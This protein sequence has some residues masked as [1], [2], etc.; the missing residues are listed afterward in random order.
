[1]QT[2]LLR[3]IRDEHL[4]LAAM[5]DALK[6]VVTR[7]PG[8]APQRFFEIVDS[9]LVYVKE[10]SEHVHYPKEIELIFPTVLQVAPDTLGAVARLEQSHAASV[11]ELVQLQALLAKWR[12]GGAPQRAAFERALTLCCQ[13]YLDQIRMEEASIL[14]AAEQLVND[15]QW[16]ALVVQH[17]QAA[18]AGLVPEPDEIAFEQRYNRIALWLTR[19]LTPTRLAHK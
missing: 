17:H 3:N 16:R 15:A 6:M 4:S 12:T 11:A 2:H 7:G 9:M 8:D 1:M 19:F 5:L 14:P 10:F 13:R 18:T